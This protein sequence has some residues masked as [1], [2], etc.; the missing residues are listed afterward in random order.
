[1]SPSDV[2]SGLISL[3]VV[4]VLQSEDLNKEVA[5]STESL[6]S[7]RSEVTEVKRTLQGLEIE[8]QSQ[9]SMVRWSVFRF[10]L[11]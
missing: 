4:V 9:L 11:L 8:L 10:Y 6:Q 7:S 1:M 3:F 5:V 2:Y